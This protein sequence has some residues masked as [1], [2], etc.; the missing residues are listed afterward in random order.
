MKYL[1]IILL[2]QSRIGKIRTRTH[3][4]EELRVEKINLKLY[5]K[6]F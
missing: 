5:G 4:S 6:I 3:I 1:K 2:R